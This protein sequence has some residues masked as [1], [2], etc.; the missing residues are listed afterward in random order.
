MDISRTREYYDQLPFDDLCQCDYCKNYCKEIKGAYP[1]VA[2]YLRS[3][4]VDIEKPFETSYMDV[5]ENGMVDYLFA[6]Y[7][8]F[9]SKEDVIE[10]EISGVHIYVTDSYPA[11]TSEIMERECIVVEIS[12]ITLKWA[13]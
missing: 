1:E 11:H 12:P 6:Q 7:D 2:E 13:M 4:G 3:I 8:V 5:D 9:G 10:K